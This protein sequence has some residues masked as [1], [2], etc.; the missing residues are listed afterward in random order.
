MKNNKITACWGNPDEIY[1]TIEGEEFPRSMNLGEDGC[2]PIGFFGGKLLLGQE[3]L[4]HTDALIYELWEN[5]WPIMDIAPAI[6]VC[7]EW[8]SC[9]DYQVEYTSS[10]YYEDSDDYEWWDDDFSEREVKPEYKQT[11]R[12]IFNKIGEPT[13]RGRIMNDYTNMFIA[14][15]ENLK[16]TTEEAKIIFRKVGNPYIVIFE[17]EKD[18]REYY[19]T[20]EIPTLKD[21][22]ENNMDIPIQKNG[23]AFQ[24]HLMKAKD[25][26]N[27][28]GSFRATRDKAIYAP[29]E[30]AV[31][32]MAAYHN[33]IHSESK[34]KIGRI[35][36][37]EIIK[38][39][40]ND[41]TFK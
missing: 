22:I 37:E 25:K 21:Y 39:I 15:W 33:M 32:T 16:P 34:E 24:L 19:K 20:H 3:Y 8:Q 13:A 30:K 1:Y 29:R 6:N 41:N 38:Y 9:L 5:G 17:N 28:T 35:I 7:D 10:E 36:R 11:Y 18:A 23:N 4:S 12:E 27:N 2:F 40:K 31:G 14:F 26:W